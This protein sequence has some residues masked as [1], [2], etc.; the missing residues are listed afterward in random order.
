MAV[1]EAQVLVRVGS[2]QIDSRSGVRGPSAGCQD[3]S[4]RCKT[5]FGRFAIASRLAFVAIL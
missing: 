4:S 2:I 3:G 1:L 5:R